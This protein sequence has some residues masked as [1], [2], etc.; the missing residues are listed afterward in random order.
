MGDTWRGLRP[1]ITVIAREDN[2]DD[3][4]GTCTPLATSN[5]T[6]SIIDSFEELISAKLQL[7][8]SSRP[9]RILLRVRTY[10][11][12]ECTRLYLTTIVIDDLII[13]PSRGSREIGLLSICIYIFTDR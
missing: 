4:E 13:R 10:R 5:T 11:D 7:L 6:S 12:D 8:T 3:E 9:F 1:L 2:A